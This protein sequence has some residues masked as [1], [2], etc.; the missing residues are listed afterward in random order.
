MP[1]LFTHLLFGL[2]ASGIALVA[3]RKSHLPLFFLGCLTFAFIMPDIDHLLRWEP[4]M[5]GLIFPTS[6]ADLVKGIFGPR[7]P[8]LLHNWIFPG[9]AIVSTVALR[10]L[11]DRYWRYAAAIA[12]GWAVHF[13]LDGVMLF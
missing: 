3:Y 1:I 10:K 8:S 2:A 11:D 9:L 5:T 13:A 12:I 6:V 7:E 4:S